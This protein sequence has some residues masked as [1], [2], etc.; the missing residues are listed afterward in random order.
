VKR[1]ADSLYVGP[2]IWVQDLA[3]L[4]R[5]GITA[6]LSLQQP[7][8]D[9]LPAAQQA[10]REA[11][12]APPE[13]AYRNVAI[14]DYDPRDLI[15]KLPAALDALCGLA[16]DGHRTYVHCCEGVNR[17][18][19]VALGFLVLVSA[20]SVSQGLSR[21]HAAHPDA[22]PYPEFVAWLRERSPDGEEPRA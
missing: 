16:A 14:R 17:A 3:R 15:D 4:R 6:I 8:S 5:A 12:Q 9:I 21:L 13:V 2:G 18:P 11:C 10:I 19:S 22:R 20:H 7:G 1:V